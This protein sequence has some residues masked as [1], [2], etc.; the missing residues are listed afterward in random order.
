MVCDAVGVGVIYDYFAAPSDDAAAVVIETG[1]AEFRKVETKG[2]DPVVVMGKLEALLTGR[3]YD[4]VVDDER[5]GELLAVEG[6]GEV[7]VLT[8]TDGLRDALAEPREVTDVATAWAE[9]EELRG[10][11]PGDLGGVL[12]DLQS[13]A[14]E[15]VSRSEHLYCWVCV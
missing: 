4:Q 6:D 15:A 8:V 3:G 9:T 5:S 11:D 12:R 13:L 2:L 14:R 1:P 10:A 7:L